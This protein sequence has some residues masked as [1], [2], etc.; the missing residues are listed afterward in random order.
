[1]REP[2]FS[3]CPGHE[4]PSAVPGRVALPTHDCP[5]S[6]QSHQ[7]LRIE[8]ASCV[9]TTSSVFFTPLLYFYLHLRPCQEPCPGRNSEEVLAS[10]PPLHPFPGMEI[11]FNVCQCIRIIEI[12]LLECRILVLLLPHA[13]SLKSYSLIEARVFF[14]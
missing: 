9:N 7:L 14:Y 3:S 6:N 4:C 12:S 8:I 5:V 1:M 11:Y 13:T 10:L 2:T